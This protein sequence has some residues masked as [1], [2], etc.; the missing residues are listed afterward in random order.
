[1]GEMVDKK[2]EFKEL[3]FDCSKMPPPKGNREIRDNTSFNKE[4]EEI[5]ETLNYKY[6]KRSNT[7]NISKNEKQTTK[8]VLR[9][10]GDVRA[11]NRIADT[12]DVKRAFLIRRNEESSFELIILNKDQLKTLKDEKDE[13]G[14]QAQ[15]SSGPLKGIGIDDKSQ[16]SYA[17]KEL[18]EEIG[19][20]IE[21]SLIK[22]D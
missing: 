1:M 8:I 7:Y 17:F 10:S 14:K 22:G 16:K 5:L 9:W 13:E 21:E 11:W 6:T 12:D 18:K 19:K 20:A 4:F 2:L 15:I 3:L